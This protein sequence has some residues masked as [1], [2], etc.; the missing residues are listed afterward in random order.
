LPE[1]ITTKQIGILQFVQKNPKVSMTT[2][3]SKGVPESDITYLIQNDLIREREKG[4]FCISHLGE[5]VLK[6]M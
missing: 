6:R 5:L 1:P 2:L 3:T 4:C